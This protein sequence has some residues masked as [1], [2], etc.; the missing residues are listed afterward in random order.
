MKDETGVPETPAIADRAP[1]GSGPKALMFGSAAAAFAIL[2]LGALTMSTRGDFDYRAMEEGA[3]QKIL[4]EMATGLRYGLVRATNGAVIV[5]SVTA[6]AATDR[7]DL[8]ARFVDPLYEETDERRIAEVTTGLYQSNCNQFATRKVIDG[9]VSVRFRVTR[10]SGAD[11]I[12]VEF[13]SAT[14]APYRLAQ[15]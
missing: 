1:A 6:D 2:G 13:N 9:G 8:A 7:L 11:M 15:V 5:H 4:D 12:D 3:Q 14:C 10:P